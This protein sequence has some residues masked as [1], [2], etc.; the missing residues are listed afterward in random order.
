MDD[1]NEKKG[2]AELQARVLDAGLCTGCGACVGLCPYHATYHDQTVHLHECDLTVGRCFAFCPRT[3]T[4]LAAL[5]GALC[6]AAAMTPEIGPVLDFY[7]CRAAEAAHGGTAQHGG[8]VTALAALTLREGIIDAAVVTEVAEELERHAVSLADPAAVGARG[9]STFVAAHTVGEFNRAAAGT[10][11]RIGVVAT[12]CQA[13]ALAKMRLK[14]IPDRD[15]NIDKLRLVIGLFCGWTLDWRRFSGLL[16]TRTALAAVRKMD[17]PPGKKSVAVDTDGGT[18]SLP[19]EEIE[20]CIRE[21]CRTCI[22]TT[23]EFSDIAVG[24]ARLPEPWEET[25][26]WNQVIVRSARGRELLELARRKGVLLFREVPPGNLDELKRA[27]LEKKRAALRYL[28]EKSGRD[29]DLLYLDRRDPFIARL[30]G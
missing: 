29:D 1:G 15:S 24:S 18:I 7:I 5:R 26:C 8:T 21:A 27:A 9:G 17:I 10:S 22:D 23:A 3:A 19:M 4:D 2:Q 20:P 6:D 28:R 16:K 14:P 13:L 25:R 11:R 12:P 30:C